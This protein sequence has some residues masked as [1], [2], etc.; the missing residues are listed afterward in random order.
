MPNKMHNKISRF[1]EKKYGGY[2][3]E[4]ESMGAM[5][6]RGYLIV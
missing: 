4:G 2:I 1:V 3:E 6:R 5:H